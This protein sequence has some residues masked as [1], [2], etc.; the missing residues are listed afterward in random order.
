MQSD[1]ITCVQRARFF[2]YYLEKQDIIMRDP[3]AK[4]V[5]Y[6]KDN[7]TDRLERVAQMMEI[8]SDLHYDW[9]ITAKKDFILFE[10]TTLDFNIALEKL[11]Q[12]NFTDD[13]FVLKVE[14][15]RKWGLL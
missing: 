9:A 2:F 10:T 11:K 3:C 5:R 15:D 14:Y 7:L 12:N 13:E 6:Y 4:S 8:L 1:N